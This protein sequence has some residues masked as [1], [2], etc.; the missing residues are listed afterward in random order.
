MLENNEL[1]IYQELLDQLNIDSNTMQDI[2]CSITKQNHAS[3]ELLN[4][5][6]DC[7]ILY[8]QDALGHLFPITLDKICQVR[9]MY[10]EIIDGRG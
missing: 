5:S 7:K 4:I 9:D 1:N 6:S 8:F 2:L 3:F 10:V